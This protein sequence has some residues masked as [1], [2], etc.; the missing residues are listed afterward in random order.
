MSV[1][2]GE[3]LAIRTAAADVVIAYAMA[4]DARD[5]AGFRALFEDEIDIDYS[6]LGSIRGVMPAQAWVDRCKVLGA[7]DVTQHKVSNLVV[8]VDGDEARVSAYVDAAHFIRSGEA[9]LQGF[10][11]GTYRHLLRYGSAG[12]KIAACSFI[13]AGCTGGRAAFDRA[14]DAARAR[15]AE[16]TAK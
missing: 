11:C 9:D 8:A 13:L 4:M 7:F 1:G 3:A 6:S 12:W 16:G 15:F 14:F 5:W 10:A 2:P